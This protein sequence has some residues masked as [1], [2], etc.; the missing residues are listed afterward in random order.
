M[1]ISKKIIAPI[2]YLSRPTLKIL[3]LTV[4]TRSNTD[5]KFLLTFSSGALL[6][7]L[8]RHRL[9]WFRRLG[10][11]RFSGIDFLFFFRSL[12][13]FLL[14]CGAH[15]LLP[16]RL[17][18]FGLLISLSHDVGESGAGDGLMNFCVLLALFLEVS[19]TMPLRCFRR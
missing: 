11:L 12:R 10:N 18:D 2:T 8:R 17:S 4:K 19:S 5:Q 6:L 14:L 9:R 7:H 15:S 13:L 1:F 16:L 3:K